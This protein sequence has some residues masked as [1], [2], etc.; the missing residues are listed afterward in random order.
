MD[1]LADWMAS[2]VDHRVYGMTIG[3]VTNT[4]D[5]DGMGRVKVQFPWLSDQDESNW[6]RVVTPMAGSDRGIYFLPEVG[7]EVLVAFEHGVIDF[8]YVLGSLWNGQDAPP[9]SN[10]DGENNKRVIQSRSGHRICFDDTDSANKLEIVS[11]NN[12]IVIDAQANT[13]TISADSDLVIESS[14]GA[15][16][17][18]G[19]SVEIS[20]QMEVKIEANQGIDLNATGEMKIQGSMVNI[21]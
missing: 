7:D 19:N 13:I 12:K 20:A 2:Q 21:N 11:G 8:P 14:N 3:I 15:I 6:A 16:Q 5:P 4:Q 17:L 18:K 10:G 1:L 9:E